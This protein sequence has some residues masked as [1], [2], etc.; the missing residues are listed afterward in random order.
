MLELLPDLSTFFSGAIIL[1]NN[2]EVVDANHGG[3]YEGDATYEALLGGP[4][5][6]ILKPFVVPVNHVVFTVT[7]CTALTVNPCWWPRLPILTNDDKKKCVKY[8]IF[9]SLC[10]I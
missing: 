1:I 8:N 5:V 10:K 4:H 3:V 2:N 9:L 7:F 6:L